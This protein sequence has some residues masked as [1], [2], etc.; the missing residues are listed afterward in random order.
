MAMAGAL[1]A[2]ISAEGDAAFWFG[3][4]Q[5][6]Y[7]ITVKSA[8]WQRLDEMAKAVGV[9]LAKL[10]TVKGDALVL[11]GEKA[12]VTDLR[13]VNEAFLPEYMA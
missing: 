13:Q 5:A 1:G 2:D 7:V 12:K 4:D 9:P 6:R 11:G 10:G 3:E 8:N